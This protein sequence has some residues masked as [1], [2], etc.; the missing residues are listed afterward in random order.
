MFFVHTQVILFVYIHKFQITKPREL[1]KWANTLMTQI[2][3]SCE[4]FHLFRFL[5]DWIIY[6]NSIFWS[7]WEKIMLVVILIVVNWYMI[8]A[9]YSSY[10]TKDAYGYSTYGNLKFFFTYCFEAFFVF[11]IFVSMKKTSFVHIHHGELIT[12]WLCITITI[13]T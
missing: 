11:D 9:A 13:N 3:P 1:I 2:R 12:S 7:I 6:P 8:E 5:A 4:L 10:Y